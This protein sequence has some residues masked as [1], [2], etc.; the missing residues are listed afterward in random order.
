M[1]PKDLS[2][3]KAHTDHWM[4]CTSADRYTWLWLL[5]L[6]TTKTQILF[7]KYKLMMQY[8]TYDELNMEILK[9][10]HMVLGANM[11]NNQMI[12]KY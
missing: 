2:L 4:S 8:H 10:S 3:L 6:S 7:E 11:T 9:C 5:H 12:L 1:E